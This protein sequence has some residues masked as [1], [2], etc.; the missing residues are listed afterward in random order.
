MNRPKALQR[1]VA[2]FVV[3]IT[4][5][6]VGARITRAVEPNAA[7]KRWWSHIVAL[8]NDSMRGRDT[9]SPEHRAAQEYVVWKLESNGVK[10]AGEKGFVQSVPLRS[11]RMSG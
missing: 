3:A 2:A 6:A 1:R 4:V 5:V 7:T 11:L 9:G 10:A 8:S